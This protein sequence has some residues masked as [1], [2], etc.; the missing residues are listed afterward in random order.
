[1]KTIGILGTGSVG[2]TYASKFIT[3]GYD[4]MIRHTRCV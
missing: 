1:M 4:V 3:L 2:Q